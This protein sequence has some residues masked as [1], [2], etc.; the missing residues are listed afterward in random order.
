MNNDS[1]NGVT[2]VLKES[3]LAPMV[4]IWTDAS[5]RW[6]CRVGSKM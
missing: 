4:Q 1:C 5:D 6:E 3:L 2:M